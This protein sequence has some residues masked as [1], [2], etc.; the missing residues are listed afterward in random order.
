MKYGLMGRLFSSMFGKTVYDYTAKTVPQIDIRA[1][2][3]KHM[4]EYK[5][6]VA[7]TPSVGSMKEN[8]SRLNHKT[9]GI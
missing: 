6:M 9:C 7:R 1:F 5:A 3:K 4:A 2:R 8:I